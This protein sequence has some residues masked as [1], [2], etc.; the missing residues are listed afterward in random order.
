MVDEGL[1]REI[2]IMPTRFF[3]VGVRLGLVVFEF[4][5]PYRG[6]YLL[7]FSSFVNQND[8]CKVTFD[9]VLRFLCEMCLINQH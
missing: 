9:L 6:R 8:C 7:C 4:M 3:F 5:L 1:E 2:R